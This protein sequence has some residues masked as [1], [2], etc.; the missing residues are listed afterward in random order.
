MVYQHRPVLLEEVI[1]GLHINL[2]GTYCDLTFGRGGHSAEILKRIGPDGRLIAMDRDPVAVMSAREN[3]DFQDPRFTIVHGEFS[4]FEQVIEAR[5]L[6]GRVDGILLDIG[7][8]S[9]QLDDAGRGFSFLRDGPLDMRMNTAAGE[10]AADWLN[11]ATLDDISLVIRD[12]G[13]EKFHYRIAKAIVSSRDKK[14]IITTLQLAEVIEDAVPVKEKHKHPATRA[15]QAIRI[16]INSE[17]DELTQLLGQ[18]QNV[19]KI[20]GR[21]CVISFHSLEDRIVKRFIQQQVRT[22]QFPSYIP[23]RGTETKSRMKKI[24][25]L[26]R[27]QEN[28]INSNV[29]ARSARLRIAEKLL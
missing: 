27:P 24:G 19:L 7:V 25:A 5:G 15:F 11:K 1:K 16:F 6:L 22:D 20:G 8:S 13:E 26:V 9:P 4:K 17:L 18:V 3:P 10:S 28:E 21:L 29:R 2:G 12:F 14:P 23:L